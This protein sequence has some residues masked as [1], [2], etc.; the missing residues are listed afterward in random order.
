MLKIFKIMTKLQL[1]DWSIDGVIED[2]TV[3]VNILKAIYT[4]QYVLG[5]KT[6]QF[7]LVFSSSWYW[8][9]MVYHGW[10]EMVCNNHHYVLYN[11]Q[12]TNQ[13]SS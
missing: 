11:V 10:N 5:R 8:L 9:E 1:S 4:M 13:L 6:L 12:C 3:V 2:L 7:I